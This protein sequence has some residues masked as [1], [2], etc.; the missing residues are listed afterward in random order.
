MSARER[1]GLRWWALL[2]AAVVVGGAVTGVGAL[3]WRAWAWVPAIVLAVLGVV[4]AEL[5]PWLDAERGRRLTRSA[6]AEERADRTAQVLRNQRGPRSHLPRVVEWDPRR[7]GVHASVRSGT[8][9]SSAATEWGLPAYVPRDFDADLRTEVAKASVRGGFL[10]LVGTSSTGKT[11]SAYE[12]VRATL[13]QWRLWYPDRAAPVREVSTSSTPPTD[14]VIWLDELQRYL[15]GEDGLTADVLR[16]L[17]GASVVLIGTMWPERYREFTAEPRRDLVTGTVVDEAHEQERAVLALATVIDVDDHLHPGETRR[18]EVIARAEPVIADALAASDYGMT[19]VLAAAPDLVR[20]WEQAPPY[21]KAVLTVAI[22]IEGLGYHAPLTT[23]LLRDAAGGCLS[24]VDKATAPAAWFADALTYATTPLK[25]A[26]AALLPVPG[27]A[28]GSIAGYTVADYLLQ[29]GAAVRRTVTVPDH[30]WQCLLA[31]AREPG[32]LTRLAAVAV[33]DGNLQH[34][35]EQLYRRAAAAGAPGAPRVLAFLLERQGRGSEA[36]Q[37]LQ[38][39]AADGDRAAQSALVDLREG[40]GT[41]FEQ[42]MRDTAAATGDPRARRGLALLLEQQGREPEA[43]QVWRDAVVAGDWAARLPLARLLQEKGR[44]L[45]IEQLWRDAVV[46]GGPGARL[47]LAGLRNGHG[48]EVEQVLR[49][50]VAVGDQFAESELTRLLYQTGRGPEAVQM[51][52]DAVAAGHPGAALILASLLFRQGNDVESA[53][54]LQDAATRGDYLARQILAGIEEAAGHGEDAEHLWREAVAA[55]DPVARRGLVRL[56]ARQ[57]R[58]EEAEQT[59]RDAVAVG[60]PLARGALADL[61]EQQGRRPETD[62]GQGNAGIETN[63]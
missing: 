61:R 33:L 1:T 56:L 24:D 46:A 47:G 31:H 15:G 51:L 40:H 62:Q 22:D 44:G 5:K 38:E 59:L 29:H 14:T 53:R 42:T 23:G 32:D 57:G 19:Q 2:V 3:R 20:R 39:A 41:D 21:A 49:E 17:L 26:T 28:V 52:R 27:P 18:A 16:R 4:A 48:P 11:R 45:E 13:G 6:A 54:V 37:V 36:K 9:E 8:A 60:D 43:E 7:L 30:I 34:I 63:P 12:A 35:A 10:L 25:G 58:N 55:G 50:A